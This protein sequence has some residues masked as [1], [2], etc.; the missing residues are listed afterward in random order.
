[1]DRW[2]RAYSTGLTV[3]RKQQS[4]QEE[5]EEDNSLSLVH[6]IN[7]LHY[8]FS[9]KSTNVFWGEKINL[10]CKSF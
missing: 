1:M 8:T 2:I 4:S 7:S 10:R 9:D 5:E 3:L 6:L